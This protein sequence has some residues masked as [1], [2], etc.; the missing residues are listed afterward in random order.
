VLKL[1]LITSKMRSISVADGLP[2]HKCASSDRR[3]K[4]ALFDF[5]SECR[6]LSVPVLHILSPKNSLSTPAEAVQPKVNQFG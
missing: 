3:K 2:L 6:V 4:Y 5:L 1:R